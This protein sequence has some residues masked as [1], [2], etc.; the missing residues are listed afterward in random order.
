MVNETA[1]TA[2]LPQPGRLINRMP[3]DMIGGGRVVRRFSNGDK[4]VEPGTILDGDFIRSLPQANRNVLLQ[5]NI[6]V[7]PKAQTGGFASAT[8][9]ASADGAERGER[10]VV[11]LGFNRFNV[12]EG[13]RLNDEPLSRSDAYA[14]AGKPEPAKKVN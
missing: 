2:R 12:I 9:S 8:E 7:W 1:A 6:A 14:L 4:W 11:S 13:V 10:H 3:L 5:N